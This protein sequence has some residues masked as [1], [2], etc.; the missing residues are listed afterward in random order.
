M[1]LKHATVVATADDGTSDVG[2]NEWN[3]AH[4]VDSEGITIPAHTTTPT[5]PVAD[6]V[7]I[8]CR[9]V[10]N[11][12]FPAW[13]GPS[14]LDTSMQPLLARN[15]VG[16]W[17]PPGG[18]TTVPGVLGFTGLTV[19]GGTATSRT[20]AFTNFATRLRRLGYVSAATAGAIMTCTN[21]PNLF[22]SGN[23]TLGGFTFI[24]RIVP[25][26]AA[27]VTGERM[28]YG[29]NNGTGVFTNVEPSTLVN[30]IGLAQLSTSTNLHI[31]YG[32]SAAST[33]INLG[34]NFPANT[35]STEAYE[36]AIFSPA[37]ANIFN[38]QVTRLST[39]EVA[40]GTL[41]GTAGTNFPA[42]NTALG[43]RF[44][45]TN[46]TTAAAVGLDICSIYIETD[47]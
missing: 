1:A 28:F 35:L 42:N 37:T 41:A 11:R 29:F 14:G 21:N 25:S 2:S 43:F 13:V 16:Y 33:P 7:T 15:K 46:N 18:A 10:A 32:G 20:F 39:N 36:L 23:G 5:T 45:K 8:F 31:C 24:S 4:T 47:Y 26:N 38:W 44:Y 17:C 6:N 27:N 22:S 9:E 12:A 40:S 19:T 34:A 3:A 30:C